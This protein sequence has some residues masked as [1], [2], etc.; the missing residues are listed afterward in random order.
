MRRVAE[1][2][3]NLLLEVGDE[4]RAV[5]LPVPID[6]APVEERLTRM[7]RE[8]P[9]HRLEEGTFA[10]AVRTDDADEFAAPDGEIHMVQNRMM[11]CIA[12]GQIARLKNSVHKRPP[13]KSN[14]VFGI[15]CRKA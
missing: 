13:F 12:D 3:G 7:G 1:G 14:N 4:A 11:P 10:R 8:Q 5:L 2:D 9:A 6:G 15:D